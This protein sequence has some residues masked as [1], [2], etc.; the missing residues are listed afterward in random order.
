M[1]GRVQTG[2]LYQVKEPPGPV[3]GTW[4]AFDRSQPPANLW[5]AAHVS[6]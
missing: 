5:A 4:Q 3:D 2:G 6:T 1:K